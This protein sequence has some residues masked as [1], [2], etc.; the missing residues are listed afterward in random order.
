MISLLP[1]YPAS[2]SCPRP[3]WRYA[4]PSPDK[5]I[6]VERHF[7]NQVSRTPLDCQA[8]SPPPL[9]NI[10][11]PSTQQLRRPADSYAAM[12]APLAANC[13]PLRKTAQ[14][15]RASLLASATTATFG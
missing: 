14:A 10:V 15:M 13:C 2:G 1:T 7:L 3:R 6:G 12:S 11:S 4:R 9:A 5:T 8:I